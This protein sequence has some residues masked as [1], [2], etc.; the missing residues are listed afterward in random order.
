MGRSQLSAN[1]DQRKD[2]SLYSVRRGGRLKDGRQGAV[3]G[4]PVTEIRRPE[5]ELITNSGRI[6]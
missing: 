5:A 3:D 4:I 6:M 2:S 1:S